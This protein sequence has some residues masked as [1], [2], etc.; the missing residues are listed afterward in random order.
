MAV[1]IH[2]IDTAVGGHV[3]QFYEREAELVRGVVSYLGGALRSGEA[4]VVIATEAHRDAFEAALERNGADLARA[5]AAGL[6]VSLD[7]AATMATFVRDGEIDRAAFR[8]AIGGLV[9]TASATGRGVRAYGEMVA[10]LWDAG[11]V[12][13]AIELE[14]LWNELG[15]ELPFALY[16]AYPATSVAGAE[17][18]EA[19]HQVCHL[20]SAVLGAHCESGLGGADPPSR[21]EITASFRAEPQAPGDARRLLVETLRRRGRERVSVEA[22]ALVLSELASNAVRHV[23]ASF[24]VQATLQDS[25]LCVAVEDPGPTFAKDGLVVRPTRGLGIVDA[26]ARR[27]GI[28]QTPRGKLVWAELVCE[29][30]RLPAVAPARARSCAPSALPASIPATATGARVHAADEEAEQP[31]RHG[32]EQNEPQH[33]GRESKAA[34]QGHEQDQHHQ[35]NHR[36]ASLSQS[37]VSVAYPLARRD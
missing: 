13:A 35:C 5:R 19:L 9:R 20:H 32:H 29:A 24:S 16:C 6:F 27:W 12:L 4:A 17:H 30:S 28:E 3:V 10:L 36:E 26:L 21:E 2:D 7:A 23:G 15:A 14:T 8:E 37:N 18:A 11:D 22:A 1:D 34:Q 33:V 31:Q 25:T